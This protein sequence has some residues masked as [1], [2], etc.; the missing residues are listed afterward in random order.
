MPDQQTSPQPKAAKRITMPQ[1]MADIFAHVSRGR[2]IHRVA[3]SFRAD[4]AEIE[5]IVVAG[6][7]EMRGW[8][9]MPTFRPDRI[10]GFGRPRPMGRAVAVM[11]AR[12]TK[13]LAA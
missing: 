1:L 9:P 6:I 13:G 2:R 5:S 7:R 12:G 8:A 11:S 10:D 4:K 3:R